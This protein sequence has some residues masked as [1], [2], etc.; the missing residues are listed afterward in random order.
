M[1]TRSSRKRKLDQEKSEPN[2]HRRTEDDEDDIFT[3]KFEYFLELPVELQTEIYQRC[4]LPVKIHFNEVC[5]G[6]RNTG[7]WLRDLIFPKFPLFGFDLK[8]NILTRFTSLRRLYYNNV[9]FT[10]NLT[11]FERYLTSLEELRIT[12][13]TP[14]LILPLIRYLTNLRKL[15]IPDCEWKDE[16]FFGRLTRLTGLQS[17]QVRCQSILV[18]HMTSFKHLTYLD[19]IM[20]KYSE[21]PRFDLLT[22]LKS[23]KN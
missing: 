17:L 3:E 2:K 4:T 11:P 13:N 15:E 18:E 12:V 23:L 6:F 21:T 1:Q 9:T 8:P 20:Q 16:A 22:N 7:G 14:E 19:C 5:K 10:E